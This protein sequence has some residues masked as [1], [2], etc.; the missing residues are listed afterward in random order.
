MVASIAAR[1]C[2][3]PARGS[4]HKGKPTPAS[5]S[6]AECGSSSIGRALAFQAGCC[7]FETRLPLHEFQRKAAS[8]K[9]LRLFA[10]LSQIP[11]VTAENHQSSSYLLSNLLSKALHVGL[12]LKAHESC[13]R[14]SEDGATHA[15]GRLARHREQFAPI[16][17]LSAPHMFAH[18]KSQ[19]YALRSAPFPRVGTTPP[20]PT[21]SRSKSQSKMRSTLSRRYRRSLGANL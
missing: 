13:A 2:K 4:S 16:C 1:A 14:R 12:L 10:L 20:W 15:V 5:K 18:R 3:V 7:G 6:T 21:M 9:G 19:R 17:L 8:N 11:P